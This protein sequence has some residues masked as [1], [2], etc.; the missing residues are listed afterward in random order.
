MFSRAFHFYPT[1]CGDSKPCA[2]LVKKCLNHGKHLLNRAGLQCCSH[3]DNSFHIPVMF[4]LLNS[5][6]LNFLQSVDLIFNL[7]WCHD[8]HVNSPSGVPVSNP[9]VTPVRAACC[10]ACHTSCVQV[11]YS[12]YG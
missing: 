8:I 10:A 1:A 6:C 7:F 12:Q 11:W 3:I 4:A 2:D 9:R 5:F